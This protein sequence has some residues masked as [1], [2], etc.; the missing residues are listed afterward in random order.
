MVGSTDY[1]Y[2]AAYGGMGIGEASEAGGTMGSRTR[3]TVADADDMA[4]GVTQSGL[5]VFSEDPTFD[6][7]YKSDLHEEILEVYAPA[8]KLG[9][10]IDTPNDGAPVVHAVKDSSPI[11][12]K[13][14]QR[15]SH[16]GQDLTSAYGTAMGS[17]IPQS[18]EN[19]MVGSTDYDYAAAYGGMGIGEASEAGGTMGSRTRQTVAD[20]D[21][22]AIGVTQSGLSVFSEDPTFDQV[23]KSDLHEEILEV[24][25]PAGKLGMVIDTPNDGAPVVHA[26]KDSSPIADK[27]KVGDK[28][29]AVDDEDIRTMMAIRVSKL[30]SRKKDNEMR[31]LTVIRLTK[32]KQRPSHEGQDLTSAYGTAMGSSIPQSHE[33][34]MVGSTDYD[35]AAAYGGMGIGEASEAGGTMGSRTRQTVADADDMAIGV[36]QS[37]LSVFSEDPTF[38]QVYKSDLHEE[39]LEVYAPAGKLGVVID[40]PNDGAPVVH[41]V[42]DSSPIADKIKVGDKLVAV[43]DEDTRT[44]T[45]IRVSKLLSRKKDNEMRKL[46]VI[47]LTKNKQRLSHEGQDL[48]SAYGTAMGSSIPQSHENQMVGSTDYDYAAAYGGMGI[49]EAS[50]AGG[51]MGSRTR[52]TVAD[53]DDM[54]IGV[55]QSGLSV[56]SEDPTFDQVYKS[57]LHEE[58]LEVYAP[59]GKLGVVIDTPNDGAPV[60]HAVKDSSPIADK[61]KVGDKLVAVDDEDTRTMTAI[62]VSKL[63]SRKK[64]NETRKLTVIR[65][66]KK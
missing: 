3:Q 61:I 9:M 23:Y 4:I 57:D 45:A 28:L 49:G 51:T 52:Q 63:L 35:Y 11:A 58:I 22:M 2:A 66:T 31:K 56:F 38:D 42:K 21:N 54:A 44:M 17:S 5:S 19:Q 65:L 27:I 59:A 64:D 50:E 8:G 43:D 6:Q 30:L 15:P 26:V 16:E 48:T 20:A 39:I 1:D 36:T 13:I 53:A 62:R 25:A 10:V 60:V 12:D 40:T 55:T 34:Q 18:H 41:A 24:Y 37:G 46:T 29:V 47:R 14:K 7:V 33:N 32:N